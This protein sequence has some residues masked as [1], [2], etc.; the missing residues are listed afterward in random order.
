M[1]GGVFSVIG[2]AVKLSAGELAGFRPSLPCS[3]K[4][5]KESSGTSL[6]PAAWLTK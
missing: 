1:I 6:I 2:A 3:I 5:W 4:R